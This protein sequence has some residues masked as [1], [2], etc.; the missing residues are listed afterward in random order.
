MDASASNLATVEVRQGQLR[1]RR[2]GDAAVFLGVPFA[3]PPIGPL[4]WRPPQAHGGWQGVRDALAFAPDFP[5]PPGYG[6]RGPRQDEDALYLNIWTPTLD[7]GARLPVM[8]WVFGGGFSA[9]SASEAHSDG[10]QLARE[11][12]VVVTVSY[13]IGLFGFLAHPALSRESPDGVSGNY[14]LRDQMAPF[15]RLREN[16][17]SFGGDPRRVTAFG[18]SAGAASIALLLTAPPACGLFAQGARPDHAARAAADPGWLPD[19]RRRTQ[20]TRGRTLPVRAA[21]RRQQRG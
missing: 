10:M 9:G 6:L 3:A 2:S 13:R 17:E 4:R 14:G 21:H 19:R 11:G 5:Q 20:G 8:A 12:V 18:Y 16:I 15:A 1:G 7:R